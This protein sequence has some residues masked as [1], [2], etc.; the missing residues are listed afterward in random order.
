MGERAG[1]VLNKSLLCQF[2][3]SAFQLLFDRRG[4]TEA[5]TVGVGQRAGQ[6]RTGQDSE[7]T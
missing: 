1:R 6:G 3:F 5:G 7:D 4:L 2:S